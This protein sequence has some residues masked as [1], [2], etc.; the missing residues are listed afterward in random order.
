MSLSLVA[1]ALLGVLWV[2]SG[3]ITRDQWPVRWLEVDGAFERVSA[4]Q[5]RA[6]LAPLVSGS[7]FTVDLDAVRDAA[8]RQAW[9]AAVTVQK[10]WPDTVKVRI[11]EYVPVAHWTDGRLVSEDAR[12][13]RVPG[14]DEI[15]GLPWLEGPEGELPEVF[16]AWRELGNELLPAG[17]DISRI[18]LDPRGAWFLALANGTEIHIGREDALPRI[19]RLVASWSGLMSG[20]DLAP[21]SVDL[22]YTNGFA[23]RWP[24]PPVTL[25]GN[26]GKEN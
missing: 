6:G 2:Y 22:R 26:Y 7:F 9:V 3:M 1:T 21:L 11:T 12:P 24:A 18:R 23:V 8:F 14:A 10:N 16:E 13:F 25:A 15:Q 20:R 5:L 4:E 17:L 19:R